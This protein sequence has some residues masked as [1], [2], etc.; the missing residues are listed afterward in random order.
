MAL[1]FW[2]YQ[3]EHSGSAFGICNSDIYCATADEALQLSSSIFFF[4]FDKDVIIL[5]F[6]VRFRPRKSAV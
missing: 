6:M 2:D 5:P 4:F 3:Q 1:V